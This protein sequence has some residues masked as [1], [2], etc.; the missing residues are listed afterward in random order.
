MRR[1]KPQLADSIVVDTFNKHKTLGELILIDRITNMTSACGVVNQVYKEEAGLSSTV[2]DREARSNWKGQRAIT[3]ELKESSL[4]D[5]QFVQK[6]ERELS[7][8]GRHTYLYN[9]ESSH[10]IKGVVKHLNDAGIV[11]LLFAKKD[12][13]TSVFK[14]TR[15]YISD[16]ITED[17]ESV[18]DAAD[19]IYK[20][21]AISGETATVGDYI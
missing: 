5:L 15:G 10:G 8:R 13:D 18:S 3:V 1:R 19:Y 20:A 4:V 9:P 12:L 21:S 16:W 14:S 6:L 17:I 2:I 7:N 11:V